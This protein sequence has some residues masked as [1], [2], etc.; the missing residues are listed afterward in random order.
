MNKKIIKLASLILLISMLITG[1]SN[2]LK[3]ENLELKNE[4]EE[5]K[6]KNAILET[7]INNLKNQLKEQ[8]A[9]MASEKE[10]KFES[11]NIYTIYTADINTYEKKAGEYI[12][13]SNETPLKQKLDILVNA[14]SEIYFKNLPIEVVKI[15]ELDK[16]KIAVINLKESKENKGVTDVSK[17]KGDTWATGFFQGSAGGAITSTQLIETILQREYRGQWIDGVRF[18]YNNGNCDFEHA[19]NLAKVNYRK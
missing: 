3:S 7:T 11:E 2:S 4:I 18:L 15:E 1:C 12:Y 6:E 5:V 13:I 8:E 16:K 10:R 17:M 14:L 9:K 19:P